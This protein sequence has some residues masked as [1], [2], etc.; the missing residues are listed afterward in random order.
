MTVPR[1]FVVN[2]DSEVLGL[3]CFFQC[4][5]MNIIG[6]LNGRYSAIRLYD[7]PD[8]KLFILIGLV[9]AFSSVA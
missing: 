7:G 5:A 4:M 2:G 8:L 6:C 3:C 9:G 1:Q